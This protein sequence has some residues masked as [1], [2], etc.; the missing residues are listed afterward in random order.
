MI[1]SVSMNNGI[2]ID[3]EKINDEIISEKLKVRR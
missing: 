2:E 1:A 3:D